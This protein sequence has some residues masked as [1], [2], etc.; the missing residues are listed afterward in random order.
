MANES[1]QEKKIGLL[2][3]DLSSLEEYI[4][5][6]FVF[7]PL[8]ICFVSLGGMVF[9]ANPA[10]EKLSN[11]ILTDI[12]GTPITI[13][14]KEKEIERLQQETIKSGAVEGREMLFSPKEKGK[15][16]VQVFTRVRQD[17]E[18]RPVGYFL[19]L[20]DLTKIKQTEEN[21]SQTQ[22]ALLNILEDTEEARR[23]A[24]EEKDK[25]KTIIDNFTDGLLVFDVAE[26]LISINAQ[27]E[28]FFNVQSA[29]VNGK[30]LT[31]LKEIL[32]FLPL[33]LVLGEKLK[34][35]FRQELVLK[36]NLVL[37]VSAVPVLS[38]GEKTGYLVS[39]HDITREKLIERMKTEF[40]SIAAHQLRT[41][42]SAIK[43]TLRMLLDGDLGELAPEQ[44]DFIEKSYQSN[45]R[46]IGL[47]NDL[48]DVTRIEEGRYVFKKDYADIVSL[49]NS[50]VSNYLDEAKEKGIKLRFKSTA[51]NLPAVI[52]DAEKITLVIQ[53][54][55]ENS[56]KY[57]KPGG[58]IIVFLERRKEE[59]E[60]SVRD[61]GVGI[62][63]DQQG[64]VF[65]KFFRAANVMRM[66]TE[67][68]GLGL[69]IAKNIVEAH[70]G[71]IWFQSEEGKGSTFFFTIPAKKEFK[72]F[73]E[74]F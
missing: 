2:L 38:Y 65:S 71:R 29:G 3:S 58:E 51:K 40:V 44:R 43:W 57:T 21:I 68:S 70:G 19:S 45:E 34:E 60:I 18:G 24:E 41:P 1:E 16:A 30:S 63:L 48:L 6:L 12:I 55:I 54:L 27:G 37:E 22:R 49:V 33:I 5:D 32:A 47:I 73:L 35:T 50:I 8:P 7:A 69:F 74:G 56:I 52:I 26:R 28:K 13:F 20:F 59:I 14:F 15:M 31:E 46:M 53:N 39:L 4:N 42:L 25:T 72:Q 66:E 9:E 11:S 67:G 10:F 17:E 36:E 61:T 64:R 23:L 62:P